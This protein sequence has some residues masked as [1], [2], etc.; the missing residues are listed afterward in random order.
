MPALRSRF[1]LPLA[2]AFALLGLVGACTSKPSGLVVDIGAYRADWEAWTADR[3]TLFRSDSSP[4]SQDRRELFSGLTY[5]DYDSTLV[6]RA[7]FVL[8]LAADTVLFPTTTGELRPMVL[9]GHLAFRANDVA[10]RLA[11]Y[12]A[13][14]VLAALA[15][16][17]LFVPF[18]DATSGKSTYG[19]G[20]YLDLDVAPDGQYVIDFNQA[21]NPYCVYNTSYSCPLPPPENTL[22]LDVTAGEQLPDKPSV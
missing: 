14:G 16:P 19:G 7:S 11:T 2:A 12:Q 21:Y 5:F 20:R 8:T 15:P 17:R 4:L 9:A 18:R 1:L 3:D 13:V 10:F 6:L 22:G